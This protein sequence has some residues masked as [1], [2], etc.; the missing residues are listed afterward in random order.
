MAPGHARLCFHPA[1]LPFLS[2]SHLLCHLCFL[3]PLLA[4]GTR[5]N[6][7]TVLYSWQESYLGFLFAKESYCITVDFLFAKES[8]LGFLFAK[9][10]YLGTVSLYQRK[11]QYVGFLFAKESYLG[12][13]FAKESCLGFLF[14]K[15]S[16]LGFLFA[17]ESCLGFLFAKKKLQYSGFL[18]AKENSLGFLFAKESHKGSLSLSL[19]RALRKTVVSLS[20]LLLVFGP[21]GQAKPR[22]YSAQSQAYCQQRDTVLEHLDPPDAPQTCSASRGGKREA[23]THH[24]AQS[25][26]P[27]QQAGDDL[28]FANVSKKE[29]KMIKPVLIEDLVRQGLCPAR[30]HLVF[31]SDLMRLHCD[32]ADL[33]CRGMAVAARQQQP[34]EASDR[35]AYHREGSKSE[36]SDL[37]S[38]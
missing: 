26:G 33:L 15:E 2:L 20:A 12:F 18:F 10:S 14:A 21:E 23:A 37:C 36:E 6:K 35:V 7:H 11:L 4:C 34:R 16:C 31:T 1:S 13:L 29:A 5:A 30:V 28:K 17:K 32:N 24:S 38:I 22:Q 27:L 8:Y 3:P 9:E 19:C 25:D